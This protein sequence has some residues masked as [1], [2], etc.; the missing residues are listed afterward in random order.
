MEHSADKAVVLARG[1]GTRMR[2]DAP[3]AHLT[4][5]QRAVAEKG[6]KALIPTGRPFLDYVL[7]TLADAGYRRVCLVIGPEHDMMRKYYGETLQYE[8]IAVEFAVQEEPLGTANAV[9]AAEE[10]AADDPVTVINS[11]N[12][13]PIEALDALRTLDGNGLAVFERDAMVR[14]SNIPP[15]RIA[16][17]AVVE[18]DGGNRLRKII[19]KP[20]ESVLESLPKPLFVS[21]NCWRFDPRIFGACRKIELSP[22]GEYEVP[23]AVQLLIDKEGASFAALPFEAGVLD[24]TSRSDVE[25]VAQKLSSL[26]VR[27]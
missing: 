26:E 3:D 1:L 7:S 14:E 2:K 12:Y 27:L 8:R 4:N 6:V 13:Y 11:D 9:A 23:D 24:L 21:M 25:P 18:L 22:R 20:E 19:E 16:K 15:E 17:F 10:F 5:G